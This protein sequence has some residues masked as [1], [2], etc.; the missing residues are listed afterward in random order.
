MILPAHGEPGG[1]IWWLQPNR[2]VGTVAVVMLD[3]DPEDLL[4]VAAA[5]DQQ[6]VQHSAR[7]VRTQRSAYA[8]A[9]GARTGVTRTSPPSE[10]NTSL[11]LRENFASRSRSRKHTRR[12]WSPAPAGDSGPAG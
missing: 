11:K 2:P 9:L 8:F 4:E 1:R 10:R 3:I 12:P 5:D 7:T 6:P